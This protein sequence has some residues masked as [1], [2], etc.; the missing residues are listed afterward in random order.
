MALD[1]AAA[2]LGVSVPA[3]ERR[4]KRGDLPEATLHEGGYSLA[5][6][7]LPVIADREGWIIDL[8]D[9]AG[10]SDSTTSEFSEMLEQL[11]SLGNQ[12]TEEVS[13]RKVAEQVILTQSNEIETKDRRIVELEG[14]L[15]EQDAEN[16]RVAT[17]LQQALTDLAVSEALAGERNDIIIDIQD[18]AEAMRQHHDRTLREQRAQNSNLRDQ[19]QT[20]HS[21]MGWWSKR[22]LAKQT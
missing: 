4:I 3:L 7:N 22:R 16:S 14:Y 5:Y 10:A 8:K 17:D 19:L 11:L 6:E 20:T 13:T 15:E 12:L 2:A 9:P 18:E 21:A 1:E